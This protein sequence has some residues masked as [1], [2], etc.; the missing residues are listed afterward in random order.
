MA[1]FFA[2]MDINILTNVTLGT[3]PQSFRVAI[4]IQGNNLFVPSI[5]CTKIACE[6]HAKYNSSASSTYAA[7]NTRIWANY[8]GMEMNGHVSQDTLNVAGLSIE[9]YLFAEAKDV[10]PIGYLAD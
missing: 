10:Y 1:G 9:N 3:P 8:Y 2:D 6:D 5:M 7:N 4:D